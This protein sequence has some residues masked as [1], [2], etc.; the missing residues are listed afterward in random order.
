[1]AEDILTQDTGTELAED[2]WL[3]DVDFEGV[4][5]ADDAKKILSRYKTPVEQMMGHVEAEKL[6]GRSIALPKDDAAD[7]EKAEQ[8][9]KIYS[10][11]GRPDSA[12]DYKLEKPEGLPDGLGW[13]DEQAAEFKT[14]AHSVGLNQAQ[15]EALVKF[16]VARTIKGME[17]AKK[18]IDEAKA[19][20]EAEERA[21]TDKVMTELKTEWGDDFDEKFKHAQEAYDVYGKM[22]TERVRFFYQVYLDKLAEG[23]LVKGAGQTQK[24][25]DAM[26]YASMDDE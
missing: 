20:K 1:M 3:N 21:E 5:G 8:M 13:S 25:K 24:G 7:E 15:L 11:L 2:H 18:A 16:D 19:N 17:A 10:K 26:D 4:E 23:T 12:D 6:R 22:T 14:I 9:G